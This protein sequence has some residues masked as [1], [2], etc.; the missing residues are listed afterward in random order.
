M[1]I[2]Y[3]CD[4]YPPARN[5]GIG[6]VVKLVAEAMTYRGH[7]VIV[8]G[9]Y[10]GGKRKETIEKINGVTVI[11][12]HSGNY[13]TIRIRL[14]NLI[15]SRWA[16]RWKAQL[17]LNQTH[18]LLNKVV[19]KNAIDLV[20]FP[21]YVDDFLHWNNL[22]MPKWENGVPLLIRIHGSV[23]FLLNHLE[24]TPA[25]AKIK[26]DSQFMAQADG[27]CA[28]SNFSK[29][30][31]TKYLCPPKPVDVIYNPIEEC[32]FH[33]IHNSPA[34]Q[35]ILF[36]GKIAEMKGAFSLIKAFNLV[37]EKYPHI[38]LKLIGSGDIESARKLVSHEFTNRVEF[39]G[40]IPQHH[41]IEEIDNALFC[42]LPSYF[43]N[44]SMAALEVLARHKT[45][46]YTTRTSGHEL[47]DDGVTGLLVDPNNINQLVDKKE[48][49]I[50]DETLRERLAHNGYK[51]CKERFSTDVIIPQMEQ[52]YTKLIAR[53]KK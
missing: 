25:E 40:H 19:H 42:V 14:S 5:G 9:K 6:T 16:K 39:T 3:Y 45:L 13:N 21:D 29:E 18:Y 23:S 34:S 1:N 49:L 33:N 2:L 4:E 17:I 48:L 43:E 37:A 15:R 8:A 46:V 52:Y 51:M 30:Y 53:C 50:S 12:W 31:V 44:F 20:E 22:N 11:R 27:I 35:T 7:N 32:W 10:W 24:G 47:I 26:Q 36:F 28:V 38:K 41:I